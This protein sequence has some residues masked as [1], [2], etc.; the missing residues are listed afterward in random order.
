MFCS[1]AFYAA[2]LGT[3]VICLFS[4]IP[5]I[6]SGTMQ[7][8]LYIYTHYTKD[9]LLLTS[10]LCSYVI[11][12]Q[13]LPGWLSMFAPVLAAFAAVG[14][15]ADEKSSRADLFFLLRIGKIKYNLGSCLFYLLSGGLTILLGYGLFVAAVYLMFPHIS[16]YAANNVDFILSFS[17]GQ[18]SIMEALYNLGGEWLTVAAYLLE[19][20]IYG[21]VCSSV[22]M[23][24]SVFTENKYVIICTPFFIK[25]AINCLSS[26]FFAWASSNPENYNQGLY[27]IGEI[28]SP[29]AITTIFS[30]NYNTV[31]IL[32]LNTAIVAAMT[33]FYCIYNQRKQNV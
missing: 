8:I 21:M 19:V 4:S 15:K 27:D 11:F 2:I 22:P 1:P 26:L 33:I 7:S 32:L 14:V 31:P 29:E 9:E 30:L 20:F 6:K 12:K 10:N 28:I 16:E 17:F 24:I 13:G 23:A 25:Y 3:A 5:D 18:G